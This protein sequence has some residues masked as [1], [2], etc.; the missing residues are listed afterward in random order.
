MCGKC[1]SL[2]SST[3]GTKSIKIIVNNLCPA[4][5]NGAMCAQS[6]KSAKNSV[7]QSEF[8]GLLQSAY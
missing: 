8:E 1:W 7:G 2:S 5:G 3:A 6:D 4:Q